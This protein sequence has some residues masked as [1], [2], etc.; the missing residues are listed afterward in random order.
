MAQ[1]NLMQILQI[2]LS[3]LPHHV[4]ISSE[5]VELASFVIEDNY[6]TLSNL[7]YIGGNFSFK[8]RHTLHTQET[9]RY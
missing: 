1:N 4:S 5:E 8:L 3:K 2:R 7:Y 9:Q 6:E